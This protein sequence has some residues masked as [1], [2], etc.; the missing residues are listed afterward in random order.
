M[1]YAFEVPQ[2]AAHQPDRSDSVIDRSH[3]AQ[4][5]LGDPALEREIL[6]LFDRQSELL[7]D[8]MQQVGSAGV[9]ALAHTL[10]GSA[11]SIGAWH[12]A[13]SA[14]AV[15]LAD[16]TL[17]EF[18]AALDRLATDVGVAREMIRGLLKTH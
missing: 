18:Q 3:L 14:E 11:R 7:V 13:R 12:V 15:E 16:G 8:R 4:M 1:S 2:A 9:S 6:Q 10:K 5:T 17:D